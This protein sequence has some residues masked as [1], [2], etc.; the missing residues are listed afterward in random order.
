M[1]TRCRMLEWLPQGFSMADLALFALAGLFTGAVNTL[2]GAGSL[3]TLPI[4]VFLCGLPAPVANGTNRLGVLA[5]SGV[6]MWSLQRSGSGL[7][8]HWLLPIGLMV[9]GAMAGAAWAAQLDEQAMNLALGALMALMLLI[10][11]LK[12]ERWVHEEPADPSRLRHPA[13]WLMYLLTGIYGGFIQAGTGILIMAGSVLAARFNLKEANSLKI[14]V[15]GLFNLPA[16]AIFAWNGQIN[17]GFGLGMALFQG[18]GAWLAVRF[19]LRSSLASRWIYRILLIVV[20]A[21]ALSFFARAMGG[22]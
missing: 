7:R 10:M 18:L 12:P 9:G 22:A 4:F 1:S 6:G 2:A 15:I 5:Q 20:A 19:L 8:P 13:V 3:V 17:W 11:L 21:S 14:W 16:L